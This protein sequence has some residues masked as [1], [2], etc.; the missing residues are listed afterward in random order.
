MGGRAAPERKARADGV[1]RVEREVEL[2]KRRV[3]EEEGEETRL[4]GGCLSEVGWAK[5]EGKIRWSG[6]SLG[7]GAGLIWWQARRVGK[8][9][10][11]GGREVKEGKVVEM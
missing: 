2:Q 1:E 7:S 3:E 10:K 11:L 5:R 6:H 8:W 4:D 9:N